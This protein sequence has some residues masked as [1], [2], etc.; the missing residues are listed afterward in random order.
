MESTLAKK[1][2]DS[3][4]E[5]TVNE[6]TMKCGA[7]GKSF[8]ADAVDGATC[9]DCGSGDVEVVKEEPGAGDSGGTDANDQV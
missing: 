3:I 8:E 2:L 5:A 9:P 6:D 4:K 7:C 1:V